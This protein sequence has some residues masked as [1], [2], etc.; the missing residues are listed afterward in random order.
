[1]NEFV[2]SGNPFPSFP[3]PWYHAYFCAENYIYSYE[4]PQKT[5]ATRAALFGLNMHQI[6]CRLGLCPRPH[7]GAHS[8]L[9]DPLAGLRTSTSKGM[10]RK[11]RGRDGLSPPYCYLRFVPCVRT[12][13]IIIDI[14]NKTNTFSI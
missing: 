14:I 5:V 2:D 8:T 4:N 3:F 12:G 7:W 10:G 9:P 11:W 6:V 1:M 13:N